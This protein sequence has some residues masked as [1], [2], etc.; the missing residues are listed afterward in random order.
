MRALLIAEKPS[1]RRTIEAV[2][3]KHIKEIPYQIDFMDQRGHLL[4]L[5]LPD[6]MDASLKKWSWSTLPIEPEKLGGWRYKVIQERKT[7]NFLTSAER[8]EAIKKKLQTENYDFI[9]NAGDPDQEGELLIRIVL[10]ELKREFLESSFESDNGSNKTLDDKSGNQ[11]DIKSDNELDNLSKLNQYGESNNNSRTK[12]TIPIKRFWSND[13]TEPKVLEALI[14]LRDDDN[15]PMLVNLLK[16]AYARQHSDYRVGMNISRAASLKMDSRVAC[17]RV[18]T[19]IMSIVCRRELEILNFVPSTVYGVKVKYEEGFE[20]QLAEPGVLNA[21]AKSKSKGSKADNEATDGAADKAPAADKKKQGKKEADGAKGEESEEREEGAGLIWFDTKEE[22]EALIKTLSGPAKVLKFQ[23]RKQE[24]QPPKLYKLAT[25]QIAAGKLGYSSAKTLEIVQSLYEK[26]YVSYPRT[27]CE[28]ISS[29]EK[30]Y[31]L[32]RSCMGVPELEEY[33]KTITNGAIKKVQSSNRWVNDK[34]L[35][36][37]GHSALIPTTYKP[38]FAKLTKEQQDIYRLICRQFT[39]I[40]LPPLVQK[41]VELVADISGQMFRSTGKTLVDEGYSK[42]FGTKSTDAMIPQH[43]A[44]DL[45]P[46]ES[47]ELAEKTSSCPKRFTDADLIAVC[48]APHRFLTDMSHKALGRALKI[49]T[50]ATRASIIEELIKRDK[51]LQRKKEKKTEYIVPTDDGMH[52][53]ERLKDRK[54][55]QVDMTAEWEEQLELIREGKLELNSFEESMRQDVRAM[56]EDIRSLGTADRRSGVRGT[57]NVVG[58]DQKTATRSGDISQGYRIVG[59]CPECGGSILSGPKGF[60]CSNYK[61]GCGV[62]AYKSVELHGTEHPSDNKLTSLEYKVSDEEF[63]RLLKEEQPEISI[64]DGQKQS[65][66]RLKYNL[67]DRK[68]LAVIV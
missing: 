51:Y 15:D 6:E 18:K 3:K 24:T 33:I 29:N 58:R 50:S 52:I 64:G 39:A 49:G 55:C 32:L 27:D 66:Y 5:V 57:G 25:L 60:F 62:G 26:G 19:P 35:Q 16:A 48:E 38:D 53:Y 8:Y 41:K 21:G 67:A 43:K 68:I 13:T 1:L 12:A 23:S 34:K 40:F 4:T 47:F 28:F 14:N 56:I 22:A 59:K 17:G 65:K 42:I 10:A 30:L 11:S 36:E 9:I 44:G 46:T 63:A 61:K 45:I 54:I 7:G 31:E 2:Y 37:A 20:G